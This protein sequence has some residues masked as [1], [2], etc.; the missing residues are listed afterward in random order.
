MRYP[1]HSIATSHQTV[2]YTLLIMTKTGSDS[3]IHIEEVGESSSLLVPG[4]VVNLEVD[5][6]LLFVPSDSPGDI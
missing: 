2:K 4:E 6:T 5:T 3:V 1:C